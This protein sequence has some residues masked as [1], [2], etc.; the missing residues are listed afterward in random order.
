[1]QDFEQLYRQHAPH[2][3]RRAQ[4]ILGTEDEAIEILQEI[5]FSLFQDP[6][7]HRH[8]SSLATFLYRVTTNACLM[9]IRSERNRARLRVLHHDFLVPASTNRALGPEEFLELQRQLRELPQELAHVAIYRFWDGLSQN[10]IADV[11][12]CSRRHVNNLLARLREWNQEVD[13]QIS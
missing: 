10:E 6:T 13:A 1:M 4:Q 11:M 8:E 3:L 5:F 2:V 9:R 12:L 7:Q